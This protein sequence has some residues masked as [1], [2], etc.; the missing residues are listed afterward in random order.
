MGVPR[1]LKQVLQTGAGARIEAP[2]APRSST[3]GTRIEAPKV[4]RGVGC[5]EGVSPSPLGVGSENFC[6]FLLKNGVF[7]CILM[8]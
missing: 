4:P 3:E 8:Y 1:T 2:K 5:G 7:W 6:N